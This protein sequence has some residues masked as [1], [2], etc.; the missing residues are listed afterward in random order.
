MEFEKLLGKISVAEFRKFVLLYSLSNPEFKTEV[1]VYFSDKDEKLDL[2]KKYNEWIKKTIRKYERR[3]FID[4]NSSSN[5][6]DELQGIINTGFVLVEK[7]NFV[8]AFALAKVAL[9]ETMQVI[10][11]C[12]D[13][14]GHI[15]DTILFSIQLLESI[16]GNPYAANPLKKEIFVHLETILKDDIYFDYGDFGYQLLDLFESMAITMR[17]DGTFLKHLDNELAKPTS[18]YSDYRTDFYKVRKI[19]FLDAVGR[20]EEASMLMFQNMHIVEIRQKIIDMAIIESDYLRAKNLILEGVEIAQEKNLPGLVSRWFKEFLRVAFLENDIEAIRHYGKYFAFERGVDAEYYRV[21][22]N[23]YSPGEWKDLIDL[24]IDEK[25]SEAADSYAAHRARGWAGQS[26]LSLLSTVALIYIEENYLDRLLVLVKQE[27]DLDRILNYHD[28]LL[29]EYP[30]DL[31]QVYIPAIKKA[32]E[33]TSDRKQYKVLVK[34]IKRIV[35]DIPE[36]KEV[37]LQIAK[38]LKIAYHRRPA[39][40]EELTKLI[41]SFG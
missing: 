22:K 16:A 4:Y 32:A 30:S 12:D 17:E 15:G 40:V 25:I 39:M 36:G 29:K 7:Q 1:E 20:E 27:D 2:G 13:S 8:D 34:Q 33:N 14:S 26:M 9:K 10:T 35:K 18:R 37:I 3:G 38:E 41:E 19:E 5:L 31:L 28:V 23:T 11:Y 24:Y 21:W 6:A